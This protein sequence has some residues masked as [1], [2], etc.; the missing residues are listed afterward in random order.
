[1]SR[2]EGREEA[3]VCFTRACG[4]EQR[5]RAKDVLI[6]LV[7][8]S[9]VSR[10]L[11]NPRPAPASLTRHTLRSPAR[12]HTHTHTL[13]LGCLRLARPVREA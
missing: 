5:F 2:E 11:N 6:N 3:D 9:K 10:P 12:A 8:I 1:M 4:D 7:Q 13:S